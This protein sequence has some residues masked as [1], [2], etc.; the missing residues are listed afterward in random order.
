MVARS[1]G[2]CNADSSLRHGHRVEFLELVR[3]VIADPVPLRHRLVLV[4]PVMGS[5]EPPQR[6]RERIAGCLGG[7]NEIP[8]EVLGRGLLLGGKGRI[9]RV[10]GCLDSRRR[11]C[12]LGRGRGRQRRYRGWYTEA[13]G[14]WLESHGF[15]HPRHACAFAYLLLV[16]STLTCS[17]KA[18]SGF[19][20][21]S[22]FDRSGTDSQ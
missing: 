12:S 8:E 21:A 6:I 18:S 17:D 3:Q 5:F 15:L 7:S 20:P 10:V 16:P 14:G 4:V 19:P 1:P 9:L 11:L 13:P 2:V 22:G